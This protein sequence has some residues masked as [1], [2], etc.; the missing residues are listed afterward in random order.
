[1]TDRPINF[2]AEQ[3]RAIADGLMVETRRPTGGFAR[4]KAGERLWIREPF[5]LD[6]RWDD[7]APSVAVARGATVVHWPADEIGFDPRARIGRQRF[8]RELPR[9][10]HRYHLV[11]RAVRTEPLHA[12]DD[13]GARASGYADRSAFASAWDSQFTGKA[14]A[15]IGGAPVGWRENPLVDV[16]AFTF[17][18]APLPPSPGYGR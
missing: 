3:V 10:L 1:M 12:I 7:D 11:L 14:I 17:V 18:A 4:R 8:A 6:A 16:L 2:V 5:R 9:A 13:A 15:T